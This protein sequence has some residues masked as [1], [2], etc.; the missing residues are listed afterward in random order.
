MTEFLGINSASSIDG[1]ADVEEFLA[2]NQAADLTR[3][4]ATASEIFAVASACETE[5]L[6]AENQS[7]VAERLSAVVKKNEPA[8]SEPLA[9]HLAG[10]APAGTS[11][12]FQE[13]MHAAL[14]KV[15]EER[16]ETHA[17]MVAANVLH[18]HETEKQRKTINHL[19][20]QVEASGSQAR[21]G[22][23]ER[24]RKE[25]FAMQQNMDDEL[26][27]LCQNLAS[28]ISARTSADLEIARLKEGRKV[29]RENEVIEKETLEEEV[30]RLREIVSSEQKKTDG[31]RREATSWKESY[32]QVVQSQETETGVP[33]DR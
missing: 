5:V 25:K 8:L 29:E 26:F 3:N 27:S 12:R 22:D 31:A 21:D 2:E 15:M 13:A 9:Q 30:K 7:L 4:Q 28:E 17:R 23:D 14:M 11:S 20:S 1:A 19:T 6:R 33:S 32:L 16:D 24:R 10:T 18:V